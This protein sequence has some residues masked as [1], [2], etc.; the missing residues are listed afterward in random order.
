MEKISGLTIKEHESSKRLI[1]I[2]IDNDFLDQVKNQ[3]D[4]NELLDL[5]LIHI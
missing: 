4:Q 3:F 2:K 5:S 1:D